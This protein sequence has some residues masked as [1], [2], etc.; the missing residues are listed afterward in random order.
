M[1][2]LSSLLLS[3][4]DLTNL[5]A[6]LFR[7]IPRLEYLHLERNAL[8]ALPAGLFAGLSLRELTIAGNPGAPFPLKLEWA[9]PALV[10]GPDSVMLVASLPVGAPF[11]IEARISATNAHV[12]T[13][14]VTVPTGASRALPSSSR[15][16]ERAPPA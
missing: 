1:E 10:T 12:S 13:D 3:D 15:A 16:R 8:R 14:T 9:R 4:N 5:P 7:A 6:G 11:E 2:E